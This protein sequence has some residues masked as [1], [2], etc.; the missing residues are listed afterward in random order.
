MRINSFTSRM[1]KCQQISRSILYDGSINVSSVFCFGKVCVVFKQSCKIT[2][3]CRKIVYYIKFTTFDGIHRSINAKLRLKTLSIAIIEARPLGFKG[4][5]Q[6]H[7]RIWDTETEASSSYNCCS[8]ITL[9]WFYV[10]I[11][12]NI[13]PLWA[14]CSRLHATAA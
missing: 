14:L 3:S 5:Y 9:F 7:Q 13:E 4:F 8:A 6:I 2:E 12:E 1:N 11:L 10:P